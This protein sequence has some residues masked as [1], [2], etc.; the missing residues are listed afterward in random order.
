MK[1]AWIARLAAFAAMTAASCEAGERVSAPRPETR[2]AALAPAGQGRV[3]VIQARTEVALAGP[4]V[5]AAPGDFLLEHDGMVAVVSR[6]RGTV[7][8][9]GPRGATDELVALTPAIFDGLSTLRAP[10][11]H[12]AIEGPVLRVEH[13]A[14]A[15]P[16]RLV[17]FFTFER[18]TLVMESVAVPD[19]G[20]ASRMAVGLGERVSWGNV[21]TWVEGLGFPPTRGGSFGARFL[22]RDGS[23]L[24]YALA[25]PD[26]KLLARVGAVSI[27]GFHPSA[28]ASELV[29]ADDRGAG[30]R[31]VLL[32]A[33]QTSMGA[34]AV[35]VGALSGRAV[36]IPKG[37]PTGTRVEVATCKERHLDRRPLARF[38]ERDEAVVVP[39]GCF[40]ARLIAP[41][42]ARGAWEPV[43][44]LP[45]ARLAPAGQLSVRVTEGGA[46]VPA[47][48][49]VRGAGKTSDPSWGEDP[50][51]GAALNAIHT[52]RGEA[53][54]RVP[55]GTYRVV[56]DRGFEYSVYEESVEIH[57]DERTNVDASLR[58]V[59]DTSG[60]ISADL[61]LHAIPSPDAPQSLDERVRSLAASGVEVGVATDHNEVTD[62]RPSID[63]LGLGA[64]V[65]SIVGDEVTTEEMGFGHFNVFPLLPGSS[66]VG[67]KA[68]NPDA[69]F[70]E[71]RSRPPRF[72]QTV[73][74]VNHPRMGDIGYFDLLRLDRSD[75][76]AFAARRP[77]WLAF[78]A[79]ELYNGDDAVDLKAVEECLLDWFAFL[80]AGL[81]ITGTGNSDS[82]KATF[83]E[84]GLPR[85]YV[86]T[87]DDR[88]AKLDEV[89]FVDALRAGRV[90]VSGGPFVRLDVGGR[91]PG[92]SVPPGRVPVHVVVD[93]PDWV[94]VSSVE[95]VVRGRVVASASAPF[96]LAPHR[97][98]L[99]GTLELVRGDWVV[100][101]ARG[102]K[103]MTP[104][105][106]GGVL[107]LSFTNPVWVE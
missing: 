50:D 83:H 49:Q 8:D 7:I 90:V 89:A 20:Y 71:V 27:P 105:F 30:R 97:A 84:P 55:A 74:Q 100:A 11:V 47:R 22:G 5:E 103:P 104:L 66:P 106:R 82:H 24:A 3:T 4:R 70:R 19:D 73:L 34:A 94:D 23:Q 26:G 21:S 81:R 72:G 56:V 59:V 65:A 58:R 64:H 16:V 51:S 29:V 95:I 93:A 101:I 32:G 85:T 48:I 98:G 61:H 78:D 88:P 68:T 60:Y 76:P 1:I 41:G 12:A 96:E 102:Q 25:L 31:R 44:G 33:S 35:A 77:G 43:D 42:H 37:L 63:A 40:D 2:P 18:A 45:Q 13:R 54:R 62:Y 38:S 69:L 92:G 6:E 79:V 86:A 75:I 14:S 15:L 57:A 107:P 39:E 17:S 10:V 36:A 67:F 80:D 87:A 91:G 28:R 46:P 9:F 52:E 99:Q 53:L